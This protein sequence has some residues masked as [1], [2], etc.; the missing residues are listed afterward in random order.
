MSEDSEY[1]RVVE[2]YI[3]VIDELLARDSTSD[4]HLCEWS[5]DNTLANF[6]A[7]AFKVILKQHGGLDNYRYYMRIFRTFNWIVCKA[8]KFTNVQWI[9]GKSV[10]VVSVDYERYKL[11]KE[12]IS[13]SFYMIMLEKYIKVIDKLLLYNERT[14]KILCVSSKDQRILKVKGDNFKYLFEKECNENYQ[15]YLRDIR[16][17]K[18]IICDAGKFSSVQKIDGKPTRVI[19]V[20]FE[21][22]KLMKELL[23]S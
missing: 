19:S 17:L 6:K 2:V 10:R 8:D 16:A 4:K 3:K 12:Y 23:V 9:N 14:D 18:W 11:L 21:K 20:D 15:K 5:K 1:M 13:E 22:Y 7:M